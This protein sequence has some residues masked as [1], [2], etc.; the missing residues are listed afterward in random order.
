MMKNTMLEF[1]AKV[2]LWSNGTSPAS[3]HF[4]TVSPEVSKKIYYAVFE[5]WIF[6]Q[7]KKIQYLTSAQYKL[8]QA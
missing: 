6:D 1:S 4:V 5:N 2:W 7:I 8:N 3:W